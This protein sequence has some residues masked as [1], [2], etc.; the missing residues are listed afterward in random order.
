MP[1]KTARDRRDLAYPRAFSVM[2][3]VL[4]GK[5]VDVLRVLSSTKTYRSSVA[6]VT[7]R[8]ILK[9]MVVE[10]A[11]LALTH[12]SGRPV[13]LVTGL[14]EDVR[15]AMNEEFRGLPSHDGDVVL[16]AV[17]SRMWP[18]VTQAVERIDAQTPSGRLKH[19][20]LLAGPP[21]LKNGR[22]PTAQEI[23]TKALADV[24]SGAVQEPRILPPRNVQEARERARLETAAD[25]VAM[26]RG[27]SAEALLASTAGGREAGLTERDESA[28]AT[29]W[30]E[31]G[32]GMSASLPKDEPQI[33]SAGQMLKQ[34]REGS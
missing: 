26:N 30:A 12:A 34:I 9:G 5:V 11:E 10:A 6:D 31:K 14:M 22:P 25:R 16:H 8:L 20:K 7:R 29:G 18:E 3:G 13:E 32:T 19:A 1:K 27:V 15:V 24:I 2:V 17:L 4:T 21:M 28:G 23:R 33:L